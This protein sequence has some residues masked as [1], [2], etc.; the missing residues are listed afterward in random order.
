MGTARELRTQTQATKAA[1]A[2]VRADLAAREASMRRAEEAGRQFIRD[3]EMRQAIRAAEDTLR[4]APPHL[5]P[6]QDPA[7]DLA[8]RTQSVLAAYR[9]LTAA[10]H[11]GETDDRPAR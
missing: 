6:P 11:P 5:P 10:R 9:E 3:Q 2:Q 7:T 4:E 8:E 1:L